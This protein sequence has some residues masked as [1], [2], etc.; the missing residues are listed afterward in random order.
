M[1]HSTAMTQVFPGTLNVALGTGYLPTDKERKD[2][3]GRPV[4]WFEMEQRMSLTSTLNLL[5]K[6]SNYDGVKKRI[7]ELPHTES[8]SWPKRSEHMQFCVSFQKSRGG[9]KGVIELWPWYRVKFHL[10]QAVVLLEWM[11]KD[12]FL[13]ILNHDFCNDLAHRH[14]HTTGTEVPQNNT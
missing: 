4:K 14:A 3:I 7:L 6:I 12:V 10:L 11:W 5:S 1:L 8:G 2:R 9:S 13:A